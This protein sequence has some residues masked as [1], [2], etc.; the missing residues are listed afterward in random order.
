MER[1][2]KIK[3]I[4]KCKNIQ[5]I[6]SSTVRKSKE[7]NRHSMT[8]PYCSKRIHIT[9]NIKIDSKIGTKRLNKTNIL[10]VN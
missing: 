7:E 9:F 2:D 8:Q 4:T 5:K 1:S 6:Q 10:K 3:I